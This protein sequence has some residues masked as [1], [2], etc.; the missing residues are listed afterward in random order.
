MGDVDHDSARMRSRMTSCATDLSV[1]PL[2]ESTGIGNTDRH[3]YAKLLEW[4]AGNHF[5]PPR[6]HPRGQRRN[7]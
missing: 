1:A 3:E 6:V 2:R 7:R 5:H 4:F